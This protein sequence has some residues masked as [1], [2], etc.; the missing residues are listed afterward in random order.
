MCGLKDSELLEGQ[1]AITRSISMEQ[2][3]HHPNFRDPDSWL[4][5][6]CVFLVGNA[7]W[8]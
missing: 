1:V 3:V 2:P 4:K 6:L 7:V 5:N 8:V